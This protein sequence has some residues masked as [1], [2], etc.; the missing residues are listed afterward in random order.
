MVKHSATLDGV[1]GALSDPVRR[2]IVERLTRGELTAGAIAARFAISQPAV[3]KHLKVLE[4]CGLVKRTI[5]G[6]EHHLR[7]V[8][9]TMQT[10]SQ[11]IERQQAFW[12]ASFDRLDQLFERTS[13]SETTT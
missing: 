2:D 10:A 8:P 9:R 11:W 12:N 4:R 5:V 6:R 7:L 13:E 3:S 1:F